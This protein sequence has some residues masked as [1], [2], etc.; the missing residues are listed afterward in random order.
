MFAVAA[1]LVPHEILS[2]VQVGLI[3]IVSPAAQR[4]VVHLVLPTLPVRPFVVVLNAA[5]APA[6]ASPPVDERATAMVA[7][8][9]LA[10]N[11]GRDRACSSIAATIGSAVVSLIIDSVAPVVVKTTAGVRTI[12]NG[13]LLPERLIEESIDSAAQDDRRVCVR[14]LMA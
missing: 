9:Y 3:L 1:P 14:E 11:R 7:L 13:S 4:D 2:E 8:P 5:R 6:A 10:S 12:G